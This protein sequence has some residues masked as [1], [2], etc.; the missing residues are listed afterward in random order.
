MNKYNIIFHETFTMSCDGK[1]NIL[2]TDRMRAVEIFQNV[3]SIEDLAK[4]LG[5]TVDTVKIEI[6]NIRRNRSY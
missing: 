2:V 4:L 3:G 5:E 6:T 1:T